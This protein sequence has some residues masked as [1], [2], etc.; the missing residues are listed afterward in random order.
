M[1]MLNGI[2]TTFNHAVASHSMSAR[3]LRKLT[4]HEIAHVSTLTDR[5][6]ENTI[7]YRKECVAVDAT[8]LFRTEQNF[9][10]TQ[11]SDIGSP[12]VRVSVVAHVRDKLDRVRG[13]Y[14]R[15]LPD[16]TSLRVG[17]FGFDRCG[18]ANSNGCAPDRSHRRVAGHLFGCSRIWSA[19]FGCGHDRRTSSDRISEWF[20]TI[21]ASRLT[22][23]RR[24]IARRRIVSG[25]EVI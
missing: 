20:K 12:I 5:R 19:R 11:S 24:L 2:K 21:T 22:A 13:L 15:E 3:D 8:K 9:R 1:M 14:R 6:I 4:P 10:N 16:G 7:G 18:S 17:T 23:V 25:R